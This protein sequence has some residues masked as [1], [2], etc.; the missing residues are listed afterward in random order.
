MVV[1]T[2]FVLIK[3][4]MELVHKEVMLVIEWLG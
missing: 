2:R 1:F 3:V 4:L